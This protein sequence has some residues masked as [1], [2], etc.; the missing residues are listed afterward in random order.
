[1]SNSSHESIEDYDVS[2]DEEEKGE[3]GIILV[4][5]LYANRLQ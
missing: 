3:E 5:F 2:D 4:I 1:M